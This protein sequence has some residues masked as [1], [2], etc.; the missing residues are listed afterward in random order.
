MQ[1]I[2]LLKQ[3]YLKSAKMDSDFPLYVGR[4]SSDFNEVDWTTHIEFAYH[5]RWEPHTK[6]VLSRLR[7]NEFSVCLVCRYWWFG[8]HEEIMA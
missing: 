1:R 2:R 5:C 4:V 6:E 3:Y 7:E 8:W